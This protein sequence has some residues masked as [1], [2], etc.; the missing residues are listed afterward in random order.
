MK[1]I[2]QPEGVSILVVTAKTEDFW[3]GATMAVSLKKIKCCV[4]FRSRIL[5][6]EGLENKKCSIFSFR[7]IILILPKLTG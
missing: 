1:T 3:R 4:R 2:E 7:V 5:F 6:W